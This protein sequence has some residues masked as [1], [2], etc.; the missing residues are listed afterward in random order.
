MVYKP[1]TDSSVYKKGSGAVYPEMDF[2]GAFYVVSSISSDNGIGGQR[3]LDYFY[4][5]AKVHLQGR[6][7]RGLSKTTI[8][9]RETGLQNI[10]FYDRDYRYLSTKVKRTETRLSD[11]RLLSETDNQSE[12]IVQGYGVHFSRIKKSISREYELDG[13][14]TQS[15]VTENFYDNYGNPTQIKISHYQGAETGTPQYT[16]ATDNIYENDVVNWYLG[17]LKR[18]QVTKNAAGQGVVTR[19]SAWE[20][21]PTTGL[22][23]KEVIE[24]EHALCLEKSYQYDALGNITQSHTKPCNEQSVRTQRTEYDTQGRFALRSINALNQSETRQ[25]DGFGNLLALTGPNQLTTRWTYDGFG[26]T[27]LELRADGTWTQ[28]AY[29]K[30][31]ESSPCSSHS[32]YYVQSQAAGGNVSY[33]CFDKLDREIRQATFGFNG[34]LIFVDTEYNARSEVARKSIPYFSTDT[35]QWTVYEYDTISRPVKE[36]APDGSINTVAYQGLTTVTTNPL[37]QKNTEIRD[38]RGNVVQTIDHLGNSVNTLFDGNGNAIQVSATRN[39]AEL[40]SPTVIEYD[41]LGYKIRMSE[42]NTGITRYEY[43]ALGE[44][45]R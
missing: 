32:S 2:M 17:R 18:T 41:K 31:D 27:L 22:L 21:S 34:Q 33:Q 3:A 35:P 9:D 40:M 12:L 25:Y 10:T 43:N 30:H 5:G 37:G 11:G 4:E 28:Q 14:L 1:L 6:G 38:V 15:T 19:A 20:Y 7:F 23:T 16:E 42:P 24:P 8:T 44:L 29:L 26:R 36:I 45:I 13:S 39:G